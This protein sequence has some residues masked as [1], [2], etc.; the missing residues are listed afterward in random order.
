MLKNYITIAL[1]NFSKH[2]IYTLLNISG[3]AVSLAVASLIMLFVKQEHSY[4]KWIPNG[5][6]VYRVYRQWGGGP[7]IFPN[8]REP[9]QEVTGT[10]WRPG[11]GG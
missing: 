2:R 11:G 8:H 1:R 9:I 4:D 7:G 6:N 3:L 10:R 5:E